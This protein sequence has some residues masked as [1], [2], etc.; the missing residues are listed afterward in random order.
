MCGPVV[1]AVATQWLVFP[2]NLLN[3]PGGENMKSSLD[4]FADI[5]LH[6][7][8]YM[9]THIKCCDWQ[10]VTLHSKGTV[11]FSSLVSRRGHEEIIDFKH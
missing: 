2:T 9:Q 11:S 4:S 10:Q 7:Q 5:I 3:D 6:H 1:L 8:R